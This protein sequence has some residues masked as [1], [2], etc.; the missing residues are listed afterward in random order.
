MSLKK[1][2]SGGQTGA[3]ISGIDAAIEHGMPYGGWLPKGR[4]TENGPLDLKYANMTE[5]SI[6]D[7]SER[8][9]QN[10]K[11]ADGT[12]IF[13]HGKLLDDSALANEYA[14]KHNK[15]LLHLDLDVLS[16]L[17]AIES[18][19]DWIYEQKIETLN[20]A[21]SRESKDEYIYDDVH[22]ILKSIINIIKTAEILQNPQPP[23][24]ITPSLQETIVATPQVII[25]EVASGGEEKKRSDTSSGSGLASLIERLPKTV[26]KNLIYIS[27]SILILTTALMIIPGVLKNYSSENTPTKSLPLSE[28]Q[29]SKTTGVSGDRIP[30][31]GRTP[32]PAPQNVSA[33][34]TATNSTEQAGIQTLPSDSKTSVDSQAGLSKDNPDIKT[35]N[36]SIVVDQP[37]KTENEQKG[38][39]VSDSLNKANS[40]NGYTNGTLQSL[41]DTSR[42]TE[43]KQVP[44]KKESFK[45]RSRCGSLYKKISLGKVLDKAE[46]DFLTHNCN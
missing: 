36:P 13:T 31:A 3:D 35:E 6:G 18:L 28:G 23:P 32:E 40:S 8:T 30:A 20:V 21:G 15:P 43:K 2:I 24:A 14:E 46:T 26:Q 16:E 45:D 5:M 29:D 22:S 39:P 12:V 25:K 37:E 38:A 19:I 9:E 7:Y 17:T 27:L 41:S 10:V 34:P 42:E 44:L 11:D 4:K 1:I 33:L